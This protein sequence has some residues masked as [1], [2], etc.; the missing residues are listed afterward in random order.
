[1]TNVGI[2]M[3]FADIIFLQNLTQVPYLYFSILLTFFIWYHGNTIILLHSKIKKMENV[4][5]FV[6]L[7]VL[8]YIPLHNCEYE[9]WGTHRKTHF[10]IVLLMFVLFFLKFFFID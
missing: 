3:T 5:I 6:V 8:L 2:G 4:F 10:S 9:Y 7:L 1:M